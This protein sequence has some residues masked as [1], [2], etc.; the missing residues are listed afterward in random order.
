MPFESGSGFLILVEGQI[1]PLTRL[2]FILDT[3]ATHTVVDTK[4]AETLSLPRHK[5]RV[6]NFDKHIKVDWTNLPELHLGP[7]TARNFPAMVGDLK[8]IS[9]FADGA[10]AIVGLDLLRLAKSIRID[11]RRHVITIRGATADDSAKCLNDGALTALIPLQGRP[12]RLIIDTGLQGLL[13]YED[14]LQRHLPH[15]GLSGTVSQAYAGRLR[16]HAATLTGIRVGAEELQSF[17]LLLPKAPAALS[18]DI[19]GYLGTNTLHPDMIE[20][21]FA[22]HTLRWQ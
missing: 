21:N 11:Y 13:L 14:R 4:I 10:H 7:L 18:P 1:G 19:D 2:K 17:V 5:G 15:L 8:Q 22:S 16:G 3:G 6:L 20:L 12:A 9:E